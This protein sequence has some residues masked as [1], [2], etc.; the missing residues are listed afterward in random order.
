MEKTKMPSNINPL[1]RDASVATGVESDNAMDTQI[2]GCC[3]AC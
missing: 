3:G 1:S 2:G